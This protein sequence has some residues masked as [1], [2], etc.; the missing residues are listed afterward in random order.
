MDVKSLLTKKIQTR[1]LIVGIIVLIL[2]PLITS[3][4]AFFGIMVLP[5]L[6]VSLIIY[7][8]YYGISTIVENNTISGKI[9]NKHS[10]FSV[11]KLILIIFGIISGIGIASILLWEISTDPFFSGHSSSNQS[12]RSRYNWETYANT[13]YGVSFQYPS[14]WILEKQFSPRSSQT[15]KLDG[16]KVYPKNNKLD[17]VN[18]D[19]TEMSCDNLIENDFKCSMVGG[20]I[21]YTSSKSKD[22]LTVFYQIIY[23][24]KPIK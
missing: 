20:H 6:L 7:L 15:D 4:I 12:D 10:L 2:L 18:I 14:H 21:I 23:T 1:Y 9:E 22:I 16:F 13:D 8:I 24:F 5:M 3:S 11:I 19:S 17:S